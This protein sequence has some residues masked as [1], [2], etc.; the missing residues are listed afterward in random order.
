M[1]KEFGLFAPGALLRATKS[2][3]GIDP[4][5]KVPTVLWEGTTTLYETGAIALVVRNVTAD[6][7]VVLIGEEKTCI[8][9]HGW[10]VI[11]KSDFSNCEIIVLG[12]K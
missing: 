1:D 6:T 3:F 10:N 7:A 4:D 11:R 2:G 5:L 12:I 8:F 9:L